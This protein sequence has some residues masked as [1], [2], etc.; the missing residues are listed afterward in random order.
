[1]RHR[2]FLVAVVI[3][4]VLVGLAV[5]RLLFPT[6]P[7]T[8]PEIQG[9]VGVFNNNAL[10]DVRAAG[11]HGIGLDQMSYPYQVGNV[12][13]KMA[14]DGLHML[15]ESF[16]DYISQA[17]QI[18]FKTHQRCVISPGLERRIE[19]ETRDHLARIARQSAVAGFWVLDDYPG[20]DVRHT[21]DRIHV[22]V[23]QANRKAGVNRPMICGFTG[24]L[25]YRSGPHAR[26]QSID[27]PFKQAM[28]NFT[29]R[30]CDMVALYIYGESPWFSVHSVDW[31]MH[32]VLPYEKAYLRR[33]GW[34]IKR[35][36]LVG[37]PQAF[38]PLHAGG[39]DWAPET[40][41]ALATQVTAFCK[42][43]A[44]AILAYAWRDHNPGR[45]ELGNDPE[46]RAGLEAGMENCRSDW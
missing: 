41:S 27:G 9:Q 10:P 13:A 32:R 20:G 24:N 21:L 39:V 34:N 38:T 43:G 2:L 31:T 22:L 35:E 28:A 18:S 25:D 30:G 37:I 5:A 6:S 29:P 4:V 15:D 14:A 45:G 8:W 19:R 16:W 23:T 7:F 40:G 26:W 42:G 36:P 33:R 12:P 17:C 1:M 3:L 46:L 44:S 11:K